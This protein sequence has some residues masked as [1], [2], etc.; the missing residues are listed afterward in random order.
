M[1]RSALTAT[2]GSLLAAL[3][4]VRALSQDR[5]VPIVDEPRHRVVFEAGLTRVQDVQIPPGDTTLFHIHDTP[6]LYVPIGRSATRSQVM[7]QAWRGSAV[8]TATSAPPSA[9][10][11]PAMSVAERRVFS[12]VNYVEQPLTHRVNNIGTSLFRLIAIVNQSPG[13]ADD[14]DDVSGAEDT[15]EILNRYYR[16]RRVV[17]APGQSGRP[18]RHAVPVVVVQ[19]SA[20]R[21]VIDGSMQA[22]L[23]APGM[24]AYHGG[25]GRH[26]IN[27]LGDTTIETIEVEIRGAG[28]R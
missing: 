19:Q 15:P 20:G 25:V 2:L 5:A 16:A 13:G 7:G 23:R 10:P 6:I 3:G 24:F 12:V 9:L 14:R 18:H 27:N 11:P 28:P 8:T 1:R 21:V 22:E 4:V 26:G 17:L